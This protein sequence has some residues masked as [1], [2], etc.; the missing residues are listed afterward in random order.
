MMNWGNSY[1]MPQQAYMSVGSHPQ[2]M[3]KIFHYSCSL[4]RIFVQLKLNILTDGSYGQQRI[5]DGVHFVSIYL[6][7]ILQGSHVHC[8]LMMITKLLFQYHIITLKVTV[9]H[10]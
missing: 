1:Q 9:I 8:K 2:N 6:L 3:G 10:F 5:F 4:F 7:F